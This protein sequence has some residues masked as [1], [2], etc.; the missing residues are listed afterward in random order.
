MNKTF[1]NTPLFF[2]LLAANTVKRESNTLFNNLFLKKILRIEKRFTVVKMKKAVVTGFWPLLL[3][4]FIVYTK[5]IH[6]KKPYKMS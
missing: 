1:S 5:F 6:T 4:P 3:L 2:Y